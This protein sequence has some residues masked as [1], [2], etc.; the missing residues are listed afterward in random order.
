M[1]LKTLL[2]AGYVD[3]T[4]KKHGAAFDQEHATALARLGVNVEQELARVD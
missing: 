1:F 4:H 2:K 3:E